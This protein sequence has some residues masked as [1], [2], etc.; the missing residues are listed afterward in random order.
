VAAKL[1][2][3]STLPRR[4]GGHRP[5]RPS[6]PTC[7]GRESPATSPDRAPLSG[8]CLNTRPITANWVDRGHSS[9]TSEFDT[10]STPGT[11]RPPSLPP[12]MSSRCS[13]QNVVLVSTVDDRPSPCDRARAVKSPDH[14]LVCRKPSPRRRELRLDRCSRRST[15]W[16]SVGDRSA[17]K[18]GR[19][20]S[21]RRR[22]P[23]G[24]GLCIRIRPF[25]TETEPLGRRVSPQ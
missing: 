13:I 3:H 16:S 2:G 25:R 10:R 18:Y 12:G 5:E 17:A 22:A 11:F 9:A 15:R 7:R 19:G 21:V 1:G 6:C 14:T 8:A 23:G 4:P 20:L 24:Y